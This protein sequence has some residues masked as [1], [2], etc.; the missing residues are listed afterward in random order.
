MVSDEVVDST[1]LMKYESINNNDEVEI[2]NDNSEDEEE[3]K[4]GKLEELKDEF[5]N[6]KDLNWAWEFEHKEGVW[7]QFNCIN[8][9]II[10]FN[11]KAYKLKK[12]KKK[13]YSEFVTVHLDQGDI[14]LKNKTFQTPKGKK[15]KVSRN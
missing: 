9:M 3:I 13:D 12:N 14:D 5:K 7:I 1:T 6:I 10:E 2:S 4:D 15:H 8:C 11:Y